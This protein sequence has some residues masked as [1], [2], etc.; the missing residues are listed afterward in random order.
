MPCKEAMETQ[1]RLRT[2]TVLVPRPRMKYGSITTSAVISSSKFRSAMFV[3][4]MRSSQK[5]DLLS[6]SIRRHSRRFCRR[7][8]CGRIFPDE[9]LHTQRHSPR[10]REYVVRHTVIAS[11]AVQIGHRREVVNQVSGQAAR[12]QRVPPGPD[13]NVLKSD[14]AAKRLRILLGK[15][16]HVLGL[17]TCEV[18]NLADVRL[19]IGQQR[20]DHTR[21]VFHRDRR[22]FALAE[23][24]SDLI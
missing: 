8:E 2:C 21:N 6:A 10:Q 23:R 16:M 7:S 22:S 20:R 24:Q 4:P 1:R 9:L 13:M 18:I 12:E 19:R 14:G 3:P 11:C 5:S 15:E 17:R